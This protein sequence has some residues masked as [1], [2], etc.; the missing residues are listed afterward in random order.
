MADNNQDQ[1]YSKSG[2]QAGKREEA[3]SH[4]KQELKELG[5]RFWKKFAPDPAIPSSEK[6][7]ARRSHL[8]TLLIYPLSLLP[9]PFPWE[10]LAGIVFPLF[11]WL[12]RKKNSYSGRQTLEAM[13][14]QVILGLGYLGF[15][16]AFS[17]DPDRVLLVFSYGFLFFLH[18]LF[19]SLATVKT[20]LGKNHSYPF[21]FIPLLF[22]KSMENRL[23]LAKAEL[24]S[25]EEFKEFSAMLGKI[26]QVRNLT[27][28]S[29]LNWQDL[30]LKKEALEFSERLAKL[31][32]KLE[33]KPSFYKQI[34]QYLNYFP[35][36]TSQ[37]LNQYNQLSSNSSSHS[38]G[39]GDNQSRRSQILELLKKINET[40][41][42][43]LVKYDSAQ[44]FALD[45][46][47]EAM[48]KNIQLGGFS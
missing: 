12:A 14:L 5:S 30:D 28:Q 35:D 34:K 23:D 15:N 4:P 11:I 17:S 1:T 24:G 10:A 26:D 20:S 44:S 25:K 41:N 38:L 22:R 8:T 3:F 13:Y 6:S 43:V 16:N 27:I 47:I 42:E 7:W 21:S 37:I 29:T 9:F 39:D 40:T 31:K 48:K 2:N 32:T 45:V 33:E 46:E 18:L 19:V 36:T